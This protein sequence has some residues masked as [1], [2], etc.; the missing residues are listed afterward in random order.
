LYPYRQKLSVGIY[1]IISI[2]NKITGK[3]KGELWALFLNPPH[4]TI[5]FECV[6]KIS[7]YEFKK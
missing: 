6:E 2:S 4:F 3:D 5:E 7:R 1:T